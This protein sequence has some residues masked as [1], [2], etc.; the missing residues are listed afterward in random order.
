MEFSGSAAFWMQS[1]EVDLR[2]LSWE[3]LCQAVVDR[4]ERDQHHHVIRKFFHV[5]QLG[6]VAEYIEVFDELV[7]QLLAHDPYFNPSVFTTRFVDGL[8]PAIKVVVLV[9]RPKDLDIPS[10]LA[11]L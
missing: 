8:K 4:F 9:H 11:I 10:S 5:K 7:H 1:I 3:N 6:S 2:K